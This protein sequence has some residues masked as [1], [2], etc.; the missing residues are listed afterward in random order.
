MTALG[1]FEA[2]IKDFHLTFW[3]VPSLVLDEA[4]WRVGNKPGGAS[5]GGDFDGEFG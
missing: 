3:P 2:V 1:S 5:L 4:D